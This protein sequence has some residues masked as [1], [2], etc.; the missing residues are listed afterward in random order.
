MNPS[1]PPLLLTAPEPLFFLENATAVR[2]GGT[3]A[4]RNV[5]WT[6]CAGQTWAVVGPVA[7]GKTSLASVLRG[8]WRIET[9]TIGWPFL[10]RLRAAGRAIAWP[11][12]VIHHLA[13]K[14]ESWLFS[15]GR[16]YYQQRFNFIEPHD[17][18]TL[19]AFLRAG[20]SADDE[21]LAR[22]ARQLGIDT[23]HRL[24]LIKLSN[25]EIRRARI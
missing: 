12:D 25:G 2:P 14:E 24:S 17:D 7:S 6:V 15:H 22:V 9:G 13:F 3:V 10:D 8:R 1:R 21:L 19:G 23:L 11:A 20:T 16:H 18:L 4:L 5:S